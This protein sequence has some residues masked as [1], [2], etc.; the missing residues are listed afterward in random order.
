MNPTTQEVIQDALHT[1]ENEV[2]AGTRFDEPNWV[3][4]TITLLREWLANYVPEPPT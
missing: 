4:G 2:S 3:S 1:L